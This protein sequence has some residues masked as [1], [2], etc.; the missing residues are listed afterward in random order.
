MDL[1]SPFIRQGFGT[2]ETSTSLPRVE[3]NQGVRESYSG[4]FAT[5]FSVS[6]S[7]G[8]PML[9]NTHGLD[10]NQANSRLATY[11]ALTKKYPEIE[12]NHLLGDL[13]GVNARR[14]GQVVCHLRS[15]SG[16]SAWR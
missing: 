14:R 4:P 11:R 8:L 13:I 12:P 6:R 10:P 3:S 1:S 16:T 15:R 5:P 2:Q 7:R 9:T